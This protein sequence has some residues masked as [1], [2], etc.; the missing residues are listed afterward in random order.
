MNLIFNEEAPICIILN[1]SDFPTYYK[2]QAHPND[3][4]ISN[5]P[6]IENIFNDRKH[7]WRILLRIS[8]KISEDNYLPVTFVC[9]TGA[10]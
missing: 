7:H 5:V 2:N 8:F 4:I 6:I 10:P 3:Y 9:D 1:D